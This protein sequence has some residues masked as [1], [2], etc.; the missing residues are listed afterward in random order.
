M[1]GGD[2]SLVGGQAS[3]PAS[4]AAGSDAGNLKQPG[5]RRIADTIAERIA[6]GAYA[7]GSRLPSGSQFC[8]EF[9]VSPVTI[10]RAVA[11]LKAK[12]LVSSIKGR[13]T[14]ARSLD[15]SN[16]S[17]RLG[18]VSGTW[19]DGSPETRLLSVS[20]AR[21]DKTTAARLL[22][23]EGQR[24]VDLRRVVFHDGRPGMFHIEYVVCDPERP[25]LES[26]LQLTSLHAFL[27]SARGRRFP[28]GELS[29]RAVGLGADSAAA[30]EEPLGSP[31]LCLEHLFRDADGH[32][33]SLG[34]FFLRA[35]DFELRATLGAEHG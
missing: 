3:R 9:G 14:Y 33:V 31:A 1:N 29:V 32:P 21:A 10:T 22:I 16:S 34:W 23:E 2:G 13:G 28:Q 24:V 17:F 26:Q 5:Y 27:D 4:E 30:L 11:V 8:V 20:I 15:L 35:E 25:L 12:G 18:S 19:L 7:P 6:A